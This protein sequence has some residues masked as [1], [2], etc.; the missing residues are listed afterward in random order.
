MKC[1]F[2][3]RLYH[4]LVIFTMEQNFYLVGRDKTKSFWRVLKINRSVP[5]E[6]VLFEDPIV[7]SW[8]DCFHL[9]QGING[10]NVNVGGLKFVTVCYGIVGKYKKL[11]GTIDFR[12]Y[13]FSY[14]YD[15]MHSLQ[16][17]ICRNEAT[18]TSYETTKTWN[19]FLT[20]EIRKHLENNLWTF[21]LVY[22]FFK[23][24]NMC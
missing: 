13:Y 12:D 9:L 23:Q 4:K 16:H 21:A 7:Y 2:I 15:L 19:C 11:L 24:A 3:S 8:R 5:S 22:G 20:N 6:V 18:L 10:G 14:T 1:R 17:N